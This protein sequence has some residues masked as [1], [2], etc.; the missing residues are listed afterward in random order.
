[1]FKNK[2]S[3]EKNKKMNNPQKNTNNILYYWKFLFINT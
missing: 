2:I 1:M 3:S